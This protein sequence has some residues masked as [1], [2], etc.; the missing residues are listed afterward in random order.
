MFW[1]KRAEWAAA[2]CQ[3]I[4]GEKSNILKTLTAQGDLAGSKGFYSGALK[5][6]RKE[7]KQDPSGCVEEETDTTDKRD[8]GKR[9]GM[10]EKRGGRTDAQLSVTPIIYRCI[11]KQRL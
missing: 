2:T 5:L 9:R 8:I 4:T 3:W 6:H 10:R 1:R 11:V 7:E